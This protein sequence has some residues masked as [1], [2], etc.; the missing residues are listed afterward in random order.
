MAVKKMEAGEL[1]CHRHWLATDRAVI[2]IFP[3]KLT[4]V[5]EARVLGFREKILR[6]S[7]SLLLLNSSTINS[8]VEGSRAGE[9]A[10]QPS[11]SPAKGERSVT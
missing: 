9:G 4:A 10:E 3:I 1:F 8:L 11:K 5:L 2:G 6:K 7:L